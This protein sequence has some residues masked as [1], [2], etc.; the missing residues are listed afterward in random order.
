MSERRARGAAK[1]GLSFV[2]RAFLPRAIGLGVGSFAVAG[3]LLGQAQPLWLWLLLALYCYAWPFVAYRLA[4]AARQ[5]Y[6]AE[7]RHVLFD[8]LLG[9]FWIACIG[10]NVLPTV[11]FLSMLAMNNT[12]AGGARFVVR[13]FLLQ[14]LGMAVAALLLGWRFAPETTP[15][16]VYASIP[17]LVV[18]PMT[19]G[20]VLYQL[21]I[22][23]G[24][25]KKALRE[26]SRTDSLTRLFNRGYWKECLQLEFEQCRYL[27]QTASLALIDVDHFKATND[28][29]GHIAGDSVLFTVGE[30]IR[31]CLRSED[32]AGRYGGDEFCICL[33]NTS[34]DLARD[35]L[36]RLR[37]QVA[38]L[39]FKQAPELRVSLSI[40][41]AGYSAQLADATAWLQEADRALYE[42]KHQGRNRIILAHSLAYAAPA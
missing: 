33:P 7:Q 21:A 42:A 14:L 5:P 29:H 37:D 4:F 1:P 12:A 3:V 20:L 40:G 18:H 11:M 30:Q 31:A 41:I 23:L 2:R 35:I 36:E 6:V 34:P 15:Q 19:I 27:Q 10:Y 9:G 22:Q 17:M 39:R 24:K 26:V 13:G 8:S 25:H 28:R 38:A 16:Q 32:L